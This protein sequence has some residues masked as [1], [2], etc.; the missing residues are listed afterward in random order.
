MRFL[1]RFDYY[2][3][4]KLILNSIVSFLDP[5][6]FSIV[7]DWLLV[8]YYSVCSRW[9]LEARRQSSD[10]L[11]KFTPWNRSSALLIRTITGWWLTL[12]HSSFGWLRRKSSEYVNWFK[13]GLRSLNNVGS[14]K[15]Y[16]NMLSST[17]D[18]LRLSLNPLPYYEYLYGSNQ[19]LEPITLCQLICARVNH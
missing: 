5:H 10:D 2:T 8:R 3:L 13:H 16:I 9:L 6:L 15:C 12:V 18:I 4:I 19:T 11:F 1:L 7:P 14:N 17:R